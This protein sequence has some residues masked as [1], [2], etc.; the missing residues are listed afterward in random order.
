MNAIEMGRA[1]SALTTDLLL[2]DDNPGEVFLVRMKPKF[3]SACWSFLP[4]HRIYMGDK[5]LSRAKKKLPKAELMVY[6]KSFFRHE[7]SHLRWT[8]R[9]LQYV[10]AKLAEAGIPFSLFNLFEDAR[11]EHLERERSVEKFDWALYEDV[12]IPESGKTGTPLSEFFLLIQLED[13][14]REDRMPEVLDFYDR[15]IASQSTLALLPILEDWVRLFGA[16]APS[17]RFS[18]ELQ[19]S[20]N[21]QTGAKA[22]ADFEDGT[23]KPGGTPPARSAPVKVR[24][25][26]GS[27]LLSTATEEVDFNRAERLATKFLAL[28]GV[29]VVSSRSEE[30]SARIS[31]R[32]LELDRPCYTRKT[33]IRAVAKRLCLVIDCSRSME[34]DPIEDAR[35]LAWALSHLATLGKISG[36]LVLSAVAGDTA[37]S[38]VFEF[39]LSKDIVER[40]HAFGDAEGLNAAIL[41]NYTRFAKADMVFVKTDGDICDEPIDRRE[42]EK[43]GIAVC[44][45]YSGGVHKAS[46]MG[47]HFKRFVVRNSLESLVDALLQTRLV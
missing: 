25:K 34:G 16:E 26:K 33:T 43:R 18:E 7:I 11:I 24:A 27:Q 38:E 2:G 1:V 19:T 35:L 37:V 32:H 9:D 31:A 28:F 4:P 17:G 41:G 45:L 30:P 6:L 39:P 36:C 10:N 47:K 44:G 14:R 23:F 15:V 40:I 8:E 22:L 29:R 42:V 20:L 21:L 3:D 13:E 46:D 12:A 5:C